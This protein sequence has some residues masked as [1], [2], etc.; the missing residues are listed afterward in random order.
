M[1]A[2]E[3]WLDGRGQQKGVDGRFRGHDGVKA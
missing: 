2:G 3:F 1:E